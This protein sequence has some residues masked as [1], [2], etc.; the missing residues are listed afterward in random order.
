MPSSVTTWRKSRYL[1]P[2]WGGMFSTTIVLMSTTF[3]S[4][5]S[6]SGPS[7]PRRLLYLALSLTPP[8]EQAP[9]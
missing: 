5:S 7:L 1:P 9:G 2:R 6:N 8:P 3:I 4:V